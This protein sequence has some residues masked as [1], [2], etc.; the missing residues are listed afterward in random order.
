MKMSE[1][2]HLAVK[3]RP[4]QFEEVLGQ[5]YAVSSLA[6]MIAQDKIRP[7]LVFHG[8]HGTGK[9]TLARL[10]AQ[11]INC[12]NLSVTGDTIVACGTCKSCL[13][14]ER[15]MLGRPEHP[16]IT[17]LNV[18]LH[19]GV[20]KVRQ[21]QALAPQSPRFNYRVFI[22]DEAQGITG[23]GFKGALK[24]FEDV[25][26]RTKYILCTTD[27]DKLPDAIRSRSQ[28]FKLQRIPVQGIAKRVFQVAKKEGF[29]PGSPDNLKKLSLQIANVSD[30][31]MRDA[32]GL[33]D[34]LINYAYT[35][36][37]AGA[38]W[39]DILPVM[40][41]E[42]P[43][44]SPLVDVQSYMHAMF[45]GDLKRALLA[46]HQSESP[47]YLLRRIIAAFQSVMHKWAGVETDGSSAWVLKKTS[48]PGPKFGLRVLQESDDIPQILSLFNDALYRVKM[49][50]SD[51]HAELQAA[52]LRTMK[53]VKPWLE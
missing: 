17:E 37:E 24:V 41:Q 35:K 30:G 2:Q 45:S 15:V 5:D 36:R 33:L 48:L 20:D 31:H 29:K 47:E 22:L 19:G 52:T 7:V 28:V 11:N 40:L 21:L 38:S 43:E 25:P 10:F 8:P 42:I 18:S 39:K 14:A 4:R 9:T 53:I 23:A 27:F 6:G 13:L 51:P 46:V 3:H 50:S 32:L 49:Y 1:D 16:D 44:L 12:A 26:K 34:N